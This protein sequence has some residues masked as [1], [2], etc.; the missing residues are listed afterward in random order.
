MVWL[1]VGVLLLLA[2]GW[3]LQAPAPAAPPDELAALGRAV[4]RARR[5]ASGQR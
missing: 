2:F 3:A 4:A 5:L 1:G